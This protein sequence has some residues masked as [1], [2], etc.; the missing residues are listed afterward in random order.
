MIFYCAEQKKIA[1]DLIA[2]Y[3]HCADFAQQENNEAEKP[4]DTSSLQM[5]ILNISH[6]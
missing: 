6:G 2:H 1:E 4:Q 5:Y 3:K